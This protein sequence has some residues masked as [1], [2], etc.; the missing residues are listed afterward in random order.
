[1]VGLYGTCGVNRPSVIRSTDGH[2]RSPTI[3]RFEYDDVLATY[4]EHVAGTDHTA[5]LWDW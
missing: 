3:D 1:M 2:G 5:A 4:H